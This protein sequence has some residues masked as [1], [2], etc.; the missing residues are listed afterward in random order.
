[1]FIV[2][3][4]LYQSSTG[5]SFNFKNFICFE[6]VKPNY[7]MRIFRT[8]QANS[9]MSTIKHT[10][11][12]SWQNQQSDCAP[13]EDSDQTEY[14]VTLYDW[15]FPGRTVTLLVLSWGSSSDAFFF[16]GFIDVNQRADKTKHIWCLFFGLLM[17]IKNRKARIRPTTF[18]HDTYFSALAGGFIDAKTNH[19]ICLLFGPY[20]TCSCIS[21]TKHTRCLCT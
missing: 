4:T 10:W 12:A 9:W 21:K 11:A 14:T 20:K 17:P 6:P 2:D 19:M 5:V 16:F 18:D 15:V 3:T 8:L 1:M 13:S 7:L